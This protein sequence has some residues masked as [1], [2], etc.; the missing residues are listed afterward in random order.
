MKQQVVLALHSDV[1][2]TG[3]ADVRRRLHLEPVR[4]DPLNADRSPR[5]CGTR[6]HVLTNPGDDVPP[7]RDR[8]SV[9]QMGLGRGELRVSARLLRCGTRSDR[10]RPRPSPWCPTL[11]CRRRRGSATRVDRT[12]RSSSPPCRA[13]RAPQRRGTLPRDRR[14]S[15]AAA[16]GRV[17][18]DGVSATRTRATAMRITIVDS[19]TRTSRIM[20]ASM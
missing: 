16:P 19:S 3:C 4:C 10:D 11:R 5:L 18:R 1:G 6:A 12:A 17:A 9:E 14:R 8:A 15:E 2:A 13:R 7:S 20:P